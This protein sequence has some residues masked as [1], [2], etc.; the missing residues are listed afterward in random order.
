MDAREAAR[1]LAE[2][3]Q[4]LVAV[5]KGLLRPPEAR[6]LGRVSAQDVAHGGAGDLE[7]A[8]DSAHALST[9]S[10]FKDR[11]PD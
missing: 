8:A 6:H 10:Q 7:R 2:Q 5:L 4:D 11:L 1:A 9:A 3:P